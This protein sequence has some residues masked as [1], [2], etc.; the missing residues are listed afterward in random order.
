MTL[1]TGLSLQL[2]LSVV[3]LVFLG[4]TTLVLVNSRETAPYNLLWQ[5]KA[6]YQLES[7]A[8]L[9]LRKFGARPAEKWG[10]IGR[11]ISPGVILEV[12][13]RSVSPS[14]ILVD[15]TLSGMC[16]RYSLVTRAVK[17]GQTA[18]EHPASPLKE[19]GWYLTPVDFKFER[20]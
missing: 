17:A 13:G 10:T 19:F 7:S 4:A 1:R 5:L 18:E 15:A 9:F 16:G 8:L 6:E 3:V 20:Q 14:E 2:L 11:E 12:S